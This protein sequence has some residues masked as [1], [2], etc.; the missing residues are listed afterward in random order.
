[1]QIDWQAHPAMHIPWTFFAPGLT[2]RAPPRTHRHQFKQT[3]FTP[4]LERSGVRIFLAAAMA[5]EAA[6]SP[7]HA[8]QLIL[9]QLA[10]VEEFVAAHSD[11]FALARSPEEARALL[12]A[13]D[14]IVVVHSIE[15]GHW[16]LDSPEDAQ[17]WAAQGVALITL[18]HLRDD[19]LGGAG[20]L[21]IPIGPAINPRGARALRR[22]AHRG[23]TERGRAAIVEL[24]AAGILVD[25]SHMTRASIDDA[26]QV[27]EEHGI[28]PVVTHGALASLRMTDRGFLDRQVVAIYRLG[29]VFSLGLDG[30]HL[31]PIS[32]TIP[33]DPDVCRGTLE[34]F[35]AHTR[36][37]RDLVQR[38]AANILG[39]GIDPASDAARDRLAVGW[40]SD[41]NGWT[42]HSAPVDGRCRDAA[43]RQ[44]PLPIDSLGLAHPGL[45]PD[46]WTRLERDGLDLDPML[47]SAERF[48]QLWEAARAR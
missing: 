4:W 19:E 1:M 40:S 7:A 30:G 48:L 12:A 31:D 11:R 17:L 33:V 45:L 42:A 43:D 24:D 38:N 21:P 8:R 18:V 9:R 47:R 13:T 28:A 25:L 32:P 3:V 39:T 5:A 29:G 44:D 36:A 41:W 6:T 26:L 22:G 15:G 14:K 20:I 46:H 27:A 23:L 2:D 35:A 16:L 37:V 10:Y 34:S